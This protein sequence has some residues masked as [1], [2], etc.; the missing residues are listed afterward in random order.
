MLLCPSCTRKKCTMGVACPF[1]H[2]R[3]ELNS[4]P[5]LSK[6][7][8]CASRLRQ[9]KRCQGKRCFSPK[10]SWRPFFWNADGNRN[11]LILPE[12]NFFKRKFVAQGGWHRAMGCLPKFTPRLRVRCLRCN[13]VYCKFAHGPQPWA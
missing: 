6:T 3:E 13:D 2:S 1:A 10:F 7:K 8:L 9:K 5:D 4:P 11:S 12:V